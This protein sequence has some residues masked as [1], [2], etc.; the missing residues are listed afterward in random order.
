MEFPAREASESRFNSRR[1]GRMLSK[2][3]MAVEAQQRF[4][5]WVSD[6]KAICKPPLAL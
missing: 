3:N 4:P 5:A 2:C 6:L 1:F